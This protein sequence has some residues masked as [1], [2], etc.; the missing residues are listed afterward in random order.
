MVDSAEEEYKYYEKPWEGANEK[1]MKAIRG[2]VGGENT[3]ISVDKL[4][5]QDAK[6]TNIN[7]VLDATIDDET[8]VPNEIRVILGRPAAELA[9]FI[10]IDVVKVDGST[11]ETEQSAI[12][13]KLKSQDIDLTKVTGIGRDQAQ[14]KAVDGGDANAAGDNQDETTSEKRLELGRYWAMVYRILHAQTIHIGVGLEEYRKWYDKAFVNDTDVHVEWD[15]GKYTEKQRV[16]TIL[17]GSYIVGNYI[18]DAR[19]K[20][21]VWLVYKKKSENSF[22]KGM[23]KVGDDRVTWT[24]YGAAIGKTSVRLE[25]ILSASKKLRGPYYTEKEVKGAITNQ[26]SKDALRAV[27]ADNKFWIKCGR[28]KIEI[29]GKVYTKFEVGSRRVGNAVSSVGRAIRAIFSSKIDLS[30]VG[31][32]IAAGGLGGFYLVSGDPVGLQAMVS[33]GA[34]ATGVSIA[35]FREA[36]LY[37][38]GP[39]SQT[40]QEM[41][42]E[43]ESSTVGD[44]AASAAIPR[45]DD[46]FNLNAFFVDA[47][48]SMCALALQNAERAAFAVTHP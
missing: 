25:D 11:T 6:I 41:L 16:G 30:L 42:R 26:P 4:A 13:K 14:E 18:R 31:G 19:H 2:I 34:L 9:S 5:T 35:G 33:L 20:Q 47:S 43:T 3:R 17:V 7:T 39:A 28:P 10:S 38:T 40:N 15:I 12:T 22:E 1:R 23:F 44:E 45:I 27:V 36:Y 48:P 46:T 29:D 24:E 21:K 37:G 32:T 8:K